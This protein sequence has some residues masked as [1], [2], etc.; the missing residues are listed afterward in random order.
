MPIWQGGYVCYTLIAGILPVIAITAIH[1]PVAAGLERHL[2]GAAAAVANYFIHLAVAGAPVVA[3][4]TVALVG[5][6]AG[7]AG[8]LILKALLSEESLFRGGEYEFGATV[9][10]G[11]SFVGVH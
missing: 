9:T 2:G 1:G 8:G 10:A 3:A 6:A 5:P 11:K 4:I 7:A